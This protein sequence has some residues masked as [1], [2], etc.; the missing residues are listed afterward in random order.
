MRCTFMCQV[1]WL[2]GRDILRELGQPIDADAR[3]FCVIMYSAA[4]ALATEDKRFLVFERKDT[5]QQHYATVKEWWK[6]HIQY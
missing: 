6:M 1:F 5:Y 4:M 3:F 2:C